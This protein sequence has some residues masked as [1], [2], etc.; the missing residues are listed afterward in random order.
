MALANPHSIAWLAV[1]SAVALPA[2][3]PHL[4]VAAAVA[5]AMQRK[6][7][8]AA[9]AHLDEAVR[10]HPDD[11]RILRE[12]AYWRGQLGDLDG[13]IAD[14][15]RA[16]ELAPNEAA[17]WIERGYLRTQK[18][19]HADAL[20][21][22]DRAVELAPNEATAF[23]D[24]GD[25]KQAMGDLLGARADY[26]RAIELRPDFGAAFHNRA[27]VAFRLGAFAAAVADQGKAIRLTAPNPEMWLFQANAQLQT[28]QFD[29]AVSSC[30]RGLEIDERYD[31]LG[32]VRAQ[33]NVRR[34]RLPAA[35][36]DLEK[37]IPGQSPRLD[38]SELAMRHQRLG[39]YRLLQGDQNGAVQAL[40]RARETAPWIRSFA[41][42]MLWCA[43][44]KGP[45]ADAAL[46]VALSD[47]PAKTPVETILAACLG[48]SL[49]GSLASDGD[50]VRCM[51]WF[52][53]GWRARRDGDEA[54]ADRWFRAALA[55][56]RSDMIQWEMALVAAGLATMPPP[57]G[58]LG[59]TVAAV[60][61]ADPPMLEVVAVEADGP[62]FQ[63]GLS[64]AMR[65]RMVNDQPAT[66]ASFAAVQAAA[67]IG[68]RVRLLIV[69]GETT[70]PMW[71]VASTS[72]P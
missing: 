22:L 60:A 62:A 59:F 41:E 12:R 71:L 6:D 53:A 54:S 44:P 16:I 10:Q 2:Q 40:Q 30:S 70:K 46:R 65:L 8:R 20:V 4:E 37:V 42:P 48:E 52:L 55:T 45:E 17:P 13:G 56:G 35:I 28:G 26:D 50:Q 23:G 33:A 31:A 32:I 58:H 67:V 49:P 69:Q 68:T 14:A 27:H 25:L 38:D 24:R 57:R 19:A 3:T 51:A 61:D 29:R 63:Q 47:V 11:W 36:K 5:Q 66:P 43:R 18:G 72:P 39:C 15:S 21:D 34:G 7:P 1:L 9:M 64:P